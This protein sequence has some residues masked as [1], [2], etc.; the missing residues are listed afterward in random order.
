MT[1]RQGRERVDGFRLKPLFGLQKIMC[2]PLN[3]SPL[4]FQSGPLVS[5]LLRITA[6]QT[7]LVVA[8]WVC[9]WKTSMECAHKLF[10]PLR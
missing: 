3:L 6:F 9:S 4:L 8:M 2:T 5:L 10:T 7:N 1:H